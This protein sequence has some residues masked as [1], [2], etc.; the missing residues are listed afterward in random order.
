[1]EISRITSRFL[2][3]ITRCVKGPWLYREMDKGRFRD[4]MVIS[5]IWTCRVW[6]ALGSAKGNVKWSVGHSGFVSEERPEWRENSELSPYTWLLKP[7]GLWGIEY[8]AKRKNELEICLEKHH[9]FMARWWRRE[10]GRRKVGR[11]KKRERD[12]P[13]RK[14]NWEIVMHKPKKEM[15]TSL[16]WS[17]E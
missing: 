6:G 16:R 1:M 15:E 12:F 8:W 17:K 3:S 11:E 2:S 10:G 4:D 7:Q 9:H 14:K 13:E 5:F